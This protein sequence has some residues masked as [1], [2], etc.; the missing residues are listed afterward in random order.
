MKSAQHLNL[1]RL[2]LHFCLKALIVIIVLL[3][4]VYLFSDFHISAAVLFG[5]VLGISLIQ[6]VILFY[7]FNNIQHSRHLFEDISLSQQDVEH[8]KDDFLSIA[9][10]QLRTPLGSIRWNVEMIKNGDYGKLKPE[11]ILVLDDILESIGRMIELVNGLLSVSRI[12]QNRLQDTPQEINVLDIISA[13]I[14]DFTL[15]VQEKEIKI[16][17][18]SEANAA[19]LAYVDIKLFREVM[20]NLLS[21]AI[22]YSPPKSEIKVTAKKVGGAIRVSVEDEGIGIPPKDQ[23]LLFS[24]FFR[25]ENAMLSETDGAG[26]GLFVIKSYVE[27]WGGKVWCE[28]PTFTRKEGSKTIAGGSIFYVEV[29]TQPNLNTK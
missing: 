7:L 15:P 20:D 10:H 3:V 2:R 26:L 6:I 22:K 11:I 18:H 5:L 28:S 8:A 12:D 17:T 29:P 9:S 25:A 24:K 16:L 13:A 21:N 27:R 23:P 19:P 4:G 14:K 1:I